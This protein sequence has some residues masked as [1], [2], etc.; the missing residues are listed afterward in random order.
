[1]PDLEPAPLPVRYCDGQ[2]PRVQQARLTLDGDALLLSG[3]AIERRIALAGLR[4]PE[5]QRHGARLLELDDGATL[6]CDDAV[7][8]DTFAARAGHRDSP[9]VRLQQSWSRVAL[10]LLLVCALFGAAYVWVIPLAG[11]LITALIPVEVDRR[12]G[13]AALVQLD[14]GWMRPSRIAPTEQDR[15]RELARR[16]I[17]RAWR[18]DGQAIPGLDIAF[19]DAGRVANAMAL[20]GGRIVVTDA[21]VELAA[22]R[23]DIFIGVLGHEAG[24]VQHRHS[25][26]MLVQA[27]LVGSGAALLFGDISSWL[28]AA[29]ALLGELAYSRDLERQADATSL[30]VLQAN[31]LGGQAMIDFFERLANPVSRARPADGAQHDRLADLL[32]SHPVDAERIDFF[33]RGR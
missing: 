27:S 13:Q 28:A 6:S 18:R 10:A 30:A 23:D 12:L 25:M 7:A 4:W 31:D 16:A 8:W 11:R 32:S 19:R 29:P 33:R 20:P 5:R 1:M 17:A 2:S 9:V 15:L 24:H 14:S 22:G 21:L 26:R 3:A